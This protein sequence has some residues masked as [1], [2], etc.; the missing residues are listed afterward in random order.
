M[1]GI[2]R[3]FTS[4]VAI[5]VL[6]SAQSPCPLPRDPGPARTIA[7]EVLNQGLNDSDADHRKKAIAALGTV[8]PVPEAVQ[9]V[10]KCLQDKDTPVRQLAAESLGE[11]RSRDA[12]PAL[13]AALDDNPEVSFTAAK[14]LW[15]LGDYSGREI[16][17][18]VL[19]GERRGG[20]TKVQTAV[21]K[22]KKKLHNPTELALMG[23]KDAT[24]VLF[25]PA[26]MGINVAQEIAKNTQDTG[27]SGRTVAA[28]MLAKDPDPYALTLLEWAISD[29]NWV[30]R[31]AA[32]KALGERGNLDTVQKLRPLL[33][34]DHHAVRYIAAASIL[35]LSATR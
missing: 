15:N 2:M 23:V 7:W 28:G 31:A 11:M 26:S 33:S 25:G 20:P 3:R 6:A 17:Q 19:E 35:K 4:L 32:A 16:F 14:A 30:V 22:A 13:Q 34:D 21:R 29:G 1:N 8:G 24:A 18:E 5:S 10:A 12:I 9:A 27:A